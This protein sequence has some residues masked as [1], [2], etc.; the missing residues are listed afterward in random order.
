V[1]SRY[2]EASVFAPQGASIAVMRAVPVLISV[3]DHAHGRGHAEIVS[4]A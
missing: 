3:V 2:P 1:F 4:V